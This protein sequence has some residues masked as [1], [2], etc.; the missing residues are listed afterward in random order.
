MALV[1]IPGAG[2]QIDFTANHA[3][4]QALLPKLI[5][6]ATNL[7][8]QRVGLAEAVAVQRGD[9]TAMEEILDRECSGI[10]NAAEIQ[11]CTE[12]LTIEANMVFNAARERTRN[13]LTAL[14]SL[15]ERLS[16][17]PTPKTLVFLSEGLVLEQD[18]AEVSWLGPAAAR[19][20]VVLYVLHLDTPTIDMAVSRDSPTRS[21]DLT[22]GEEGLSLMAGLTR[23]SMFRVVGIADNAFT[24]LGLEISGYYLLSFAPE[25]G[26]RDGKSHKIKVDVPGRKGVE[27]RSRSQFSVEPASAMS[28]EAALAATLRAPLLATE[29]GLKLSTYTLR[30]AATGKLRILLAA[31]I[32]RSSTSIGRLAVAYTVI[33]SRGR[34]IGSRIDPDVDTPVR[35]ATRTQTY[36]GSLLTDAPG[37]HTVKLAVVDATGKRGS[38]EH[39]FT[40]QMASAGQIRV[41]DL[42]LA[43]N[44]GS[45][46][47]GG[48]VPAVA[49]DFTSDTLH[50]YLELYSEVEEPLT[51]ASVVV[52]VAESET[53]RA[54]DGATAQIQP[55][56]ANAPLRRTAEAVVTIGLLP[57]GEYVA[58]AIISIGGRRA[59]MVTR[60]FRIARPV[61]SLSTTARPAVGSSAAIPFSSRIDAF[62]RATVL[63][64]QVVGFFLD[65]VNVGAAAAATAPAMEHARAGR[66]DAALEAMPKQQGNQLAS[67]FVERARVLLEGTARGG[68]GQ[69]P[70]CPAPRLRVLSGG[71]LPRVVLRG[72]RKRS[73]SGGRVADR[74]R[75]GERRAIHLHAARRRA[76]PA[77][78]RAAGGRHPEGGVRALA[79]Q[80]AG[81][82]PPRHGLRDGRAAH[83]SARPFSN[84]TSRVTPRTTSACS[85]SSGCS[86]RRAQAASR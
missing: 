18:L 11:D 42:L 44:V 62:D 33:D 70:R 38:V 48:L 25:S 52:E 80:R 15:I 73:R 22:L 54:L 55:P 36:A 45:I 16:A 9:P 27:I 1:A 28:E 59:G 66:F 32:D 51:N 71:V 84:R 47:A 39:T 20:Q 40:A 68:G 8:T 35:P 37:V 53:G 86:T 72:G 50:G 83:R 19:G 77:A 14:R 75:Y 30:D 74:A 2:P 10:R 78:R 64:P 46:G 56:A 65:R 34:L 12:R 61:S 5:G 31:D 13:S 69:V 4:V 24:R 3:T 17:T 43:E 6:H 63:T 49:G 79:R 67:A 76:P 41:T 7:G 81:A 23:G 58:R 29:I 57:P 60:P 26:D 82:T 85:S 21:S